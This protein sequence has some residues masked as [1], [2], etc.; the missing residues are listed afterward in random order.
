MEK[1]P[2]ERIWFPE[3]LQAGALLVV[4]WSQSGQKCA[5]FMFAKG[6]HYYFDAIKCTN[7]KK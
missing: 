4:F 5:K 7:W 2:T 1:T 6:K 3:F